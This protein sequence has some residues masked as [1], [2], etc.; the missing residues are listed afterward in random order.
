VRLYWP[1]FDPEASPYSPVYTPDRVREIGGKLVEII[2]RQL[3]AI[4]AFRFVAGPVTVDALDS[5]SEEKRRELE[6]V[7]KAAQETSV[8]LITQHPVESKGSNHPR[9]PVAQL[10]RAPP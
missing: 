8:A 9:R 1:D 3:T 7:R 4:S 10:V 2:F 5:L 6:S